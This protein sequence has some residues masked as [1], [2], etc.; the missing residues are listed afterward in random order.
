V[1]SNEIQ[2]HDACE[3]LRGVVALRKEVAETFD[4]II[5]QAHKTHK[6]SLAQK[7]KSDEP[8]EQAERY[9]KQGINRYLVAEEQKRK[10]EEERLRL[11][12]Q[13]KAEE[14]ARQLAQERQLEEAVALEQVGFISEAE[15]ILAAP[16]PA[17][18][19]VYVPP[20]ILPSTVQRQSGISRKTN[21][22]WRVVNAALVPREFL[23]I[24]EQK[25][26]KFAKAMQ[27]QAR[28]AGIE[29]FDEGT[30]A[31]KL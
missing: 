14:E 25:L 24:D 31:V 15:Q 6:L 18:Q 2:H 28:V 11:E 3:V 1:I 21:W 5:E 16:T 29:F 7:K 12:A 23:C 26:N 30:I 4:P 20:V 9:L 19:P 17:L 27:E 13:K 8:L 22:K 10:A